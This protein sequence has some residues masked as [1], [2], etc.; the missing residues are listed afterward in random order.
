MLST[1]INQTPLRLLKITW[2]PLRLH[3]DST[4]TYNML[5]T[6]ITQTPLRLLKI[7]RTLLGLHSDST[8]TPLGLIEMHA[9]MVLYPSNYSDSA[10]TPLGLLRLHSDSTQ[11]TQTPLGQVG[12]GKLQ[13]LP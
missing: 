5:S 8:R 7:T 11:T 13:V 4:W 9:R 12:E 6:K 10:W 3:L 1:K 2:T